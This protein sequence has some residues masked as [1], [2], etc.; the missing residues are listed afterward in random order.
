MYF[1]QEGVEEWKAGRC[2]LVGKMERTMLIS[3]TQQEQE[4]EKYWVWFS[5]VDGFAR[6]REY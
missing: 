5:F 3:S 6:A 4:G 1:Q 2:E